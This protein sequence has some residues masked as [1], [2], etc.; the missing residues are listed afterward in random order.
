MNSMHAHFP[1]L[2]HRTIRCAILVLLAAFAPLHQVQAATGFLPEVCASMSTA[3]GPSLTLATAGVAQSF[4][5]TARDEAGRAVIADTGATFILRLGNEV[6]RTSVRP[7]P[8]AATHVASY[9][10]SSQGIDA[11]SL[12]LAKFENH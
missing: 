7:T 8:G 6:A 2:S 12:M 9:D 11:L 10:V 1:F 5:I 4:T 3:S